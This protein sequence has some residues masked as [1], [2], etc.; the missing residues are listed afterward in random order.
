MAY[1]DDVTLGGSVASICDIL[2]LEKAEDIV[3]PQKSEIVT[4]CSH[5]AASIH[6]V[7]PGAVAVSPDSCHLLGSPIGNLSTLSSAINQ[8]I[9]ALKLMV[10]VSLFFH[11]MIL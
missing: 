3:N 1:L 8:K 9:S 6:S 10:N 5:A 2:A 4:N 11:C 7:L